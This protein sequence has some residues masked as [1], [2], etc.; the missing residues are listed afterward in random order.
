MFRRTPSVVL[1]LLALPAVGRAADPFDNYIAPL[2]QKA[3]KAEGVEELKQLTPGQA[4]DHNQV[5]PDAGAALVILQTNEKRFAKLLVQAARKGLGDADKTVV[6]TF[7]IDRFVTYKPDTE[8]TIVASGQNVTLFDGF[9]FSADMGCVVPE[10]VGG[11]LRFVVKEKDGETE[12]YLETVGNAR[13]FL[14]TKP[15]PEAAPKKTKKFVLAS[16]FEPKNFNGKYKLQDDGRRSGVLTLKV[17]DDGEVT[18]TYISDNGGAEYDVTGKVGPQ[19][20]GIQFTIKLPRTDQTFQ[21]LMFT[22]SGLAL[23][24]ASRFGD[25]EL[26][27]YAT[28]IDEE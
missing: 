12:T 21:G 5:L 20:H 25:H 23:T 28:R 14:L 2:L 19:K 18:G 7:L 10:K 22:G 4:L 27:F 17:G 16:P 24:G 8:R 6:P 11:D 9:R 26:G 1:L 15:M 13:L 3:P